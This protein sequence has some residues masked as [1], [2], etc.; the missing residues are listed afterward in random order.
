MAL[1]GTVNGRGV[2]ANVCCR[3]R[4]L[5]PRLPRSRR[6]GRREGDVGSVGWSGVLVSAC[7]RLPRWSVCEVVRTTG[8]RPAAPSCLFRFRVSRMA[9]DTCT[10]D[11]NRAVEREGSVLSFELSLLYSL[12]LHIMGCPLGFVFLMAAELECKVVC[13]DIWENKS[14]VWIVGTPC[15]GPAGSSFTGLTPPPPGTLP[16][17]QQ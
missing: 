10:V 7:L 17:P 14:M 6:P 11:G 2:N 16:G 4:F 13:S 12:L 3:G 9:S 5:G 1:S 15:R 8:P